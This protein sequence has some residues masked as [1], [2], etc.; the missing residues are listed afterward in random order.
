MEFLT[1]TSI[2]D[3]RRILVNLNLQTNFLFVG[4]DKNVLFDEKVS[5]YTSTVVDIFCHFV[6]KIVEQ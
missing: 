4:T 5:K 2:K 3:C 6:M 1:L